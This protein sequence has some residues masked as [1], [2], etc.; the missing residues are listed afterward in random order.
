VDA[1]LYYQNLTY[2]AAGSLLSVVD[3]SSNTLFTAQ[4][5]YGI[6]PFQTTFTDADL[7]TRN[8]VI[9]PLGEVTSYTDSRGNNFAL[10]YDAL[11]RLTSRTEELGTT[12]DLTTTWTWGSTASS[13][14]IGKLQTVT[15]VSNGGTYSETYTYDSDTRLSTKAISIP[16]QP[17]YT[18]TYAY[19]PTTGMLSK[20]TYPKST[21]GYQLGINYGYSNGILSSLTDASTGTAYWTMTGQSPREQITNETLGNGVQTARTYDAVRGW[22]NTMQAGVGGGSAIANYSYA[23]DEMGDVAQ[24]QNDNLGLTESFFYDGDY[25]LTCSTLSSATSC[26]NPNLSISYAPNGNITSRSDLGGGT[27]WTYSPTHYHQVT[28]A[29]TGG[30]SFTYDAN[31]NA[32]TRNGYSNTWSS[33][34]YPTLV[35]SSGESATFIYGQNHQ[36]IE[37]IYT[38]SIGTETTYHVGELLEQVVNGSTNDWRYYVKAGNELVGIYSTVAGAMRYS[39]GDHQLG[40]A[41]LET[42]TSPVTY[43]PESFTPFGNRRS[44]ETWSGAPSNSDET[45]INGVTRLGYTGQTM[46]GVSM[47]LIHMNGRVEDAITGRFLSPDP[48]VPN[49]G[50]TQDFNRYSY[51][52]N[53]PLT[54]IDPTGFDETVDCPS[55]EV[56][57]GGSSSSPIINVDPTLT[58]GVG[59]TTTIQV[60]SPESVATGLNDDAAT[61]SGF[62]YDYH[63]QDTLSLLNPDGTPSQQSYEG[64][65][66]PDSG[67]SLEVTAPRSVWIDS[68]N[69]V[70][71]GYNYSPFAAAATQ[72][73]MGLALQQFALLAI[74]PPVA[75]VVPG[76]GVAIARATIRR[77]WGPVLAAAME[78]TGDRVVDYAADSVVSEI[79]TLGYAAGY[80][81]FLDGLSVASDGMFTLEEELAVGP[82]LPWGPQ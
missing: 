18:Y 24:R 34:N 52:N 15:A 28:Q 55:D 21:G 79:N 40:I 25:R 12:P 71:M 59:D 47:G 11:S 2:D 9:D 20:L 50:N 60:A 76:V 65:L 31:G 6:S 78:L 63:G 8:F 72:I 38:G 26:T 77:G 68:S 22:L 81:E 17:T 82:T 53:N 75:A 13:Y 66:A 32:I 48:R 14:N 57:G 45:A 67:L 16:S 29:G 56:C 61:N 27:T 10:A 70:D 46:L 51:A 58:S 49:P 41:N 23:Y 54:F 39:L 62:W 37:T 69:A 3:S 35:Q 4:Y 1:N 64:T 7:G 19:S 30:S 43:T 33:Y 36:R 80:S 5:A 44:G 42:A 74:G 73:N